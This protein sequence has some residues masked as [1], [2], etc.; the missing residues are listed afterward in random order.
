MK[1]SWSVA[2]AAVGD[3]VAL[4]GGVLVLIWVALGWE[5]IGVWLPADSEVEVSGAGV[6][7]LES[8]AVGVLFGP[9]GVGVEAGAAQAARKM[10]VRNPERWRTFMSGIPQISVLK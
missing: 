6:A 2:G 1:S 7:G 5:A 4:G 9:A 3:G 8:C 10:I